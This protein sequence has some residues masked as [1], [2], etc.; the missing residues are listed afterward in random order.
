MVKISI[1]M[2]IFN[3]GFFLEKSLNSILAQSME[4][5]EIICIDDE[6]TDNSKEILEEYS[7]KYDFIKVYSQKN[8]GSGIARNK[9]IELA[10]GKYLAFLDADDI[11]IDKN[12][13]ENMYY[14]AVETDANMVGA[15]LKRIDKNGKIEE[16]YDFNNTPFTYFSKDDIISPHDYGIPWAFYKNIYKRTFIVEKNICF[17]SLS[18]G[19]DPIFLSKILTNIDEIP[20]LNIDL[21]GYN[22]S[23][24]GGVNLKANTYD[25]KRDY[26][27][28]FFQTF[29]ILEENEFYGELTRYKKEFI[30][31]LTFRENINNQDIISILKDN[32]NIPKY[33]NEDDYGYLI[34]DSMTNPPPDIKEYETIKYCIFE[35]S[36]IENTFIETDRL[37]EFIKV[38]CENNI[39]HQKMSYKQLKEIDNYTF[40]DK[41]AINGSVDK[42]KLEIKRYIKFNNDILN[43]NSWKLTS[44]LRSLKHNMR[45]K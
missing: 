11:F 15:N 4:D 41:R 2:P 6:S 24:S 45:K 42:I 27:T 36:M 44:F 39:E 19:Q 33:F 35:E 9:G 5:I 43:S 32:K 28:H 31:Y 20:V 3:A 14:V 37:K 12:A 22:H 8:Q 40:E 13:L 16:N 10:E 1:I 7:E 18:R 30:D 23:A 17:P 26:I 21:Y 29:D 38:T 25:K 34:I